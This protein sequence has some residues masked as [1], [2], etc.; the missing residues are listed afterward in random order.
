MDGLNPY[1]RRIGAHDHF[2][3]EFQLTVSAMWCITSQHTHT[4][5]NT[6][7]PYTQICLYIITY[8]LI[9]IQLFVTMSGFHLHHRP[10]VR[11]RHLFILHLWIYVYYPTPTSSPSSLPSHA[12]HRCHPAQWPWA[13]VGRCLLQELRHVHLYFSHCPWITFSQSLPLTVENVE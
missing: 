4:Y 5:T 12:T 10:S 1:P 9:N 11:P 7:I 13:L 2:P 3:G 6:H 8:Y